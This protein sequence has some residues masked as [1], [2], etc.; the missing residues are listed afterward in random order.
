VKR[1]AV[2]SYL[3]GIVVNCDPETFMCM[4]AIVSLEDQIISNDPER[5]KIGSAPGA[6]PILF[7]PSL[8]LCG[9]RA[10]GGAILCLGHSPLKPIRCD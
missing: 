4:T 6:I 10:T 9:P 5:F 8:F 1:G 2:A 3:A 7:K